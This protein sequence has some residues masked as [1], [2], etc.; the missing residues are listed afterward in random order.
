MVGGKLAQ[1]DP[2]TIKKFGKWVQAKV[3][4]MKDAAR[5]QEDRYL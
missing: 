3:A 4:A 2:E 5:R 1:A